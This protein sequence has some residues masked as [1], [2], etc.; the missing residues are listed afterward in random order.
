M[1]LL[2]RFQHRPL[3]LIPVR[4]PRALRDALALVAADADTLGDVHMLAEFIWRLAHPADAPHR[5]FAIPW[6]QCAAGEPLD[7]DVGLARELF[8]IAPHRAHVLRPISAARCH[9]G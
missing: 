7:A 9:P 8:R 2:D 4:R 6:R 3:M 1:Q 5:E